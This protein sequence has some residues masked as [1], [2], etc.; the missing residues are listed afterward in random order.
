MKTVMEKHLEILKLHNELGE[1]IDLIISEVS[2]LIIEN[3]D[4]KNF[5]TQEMTSKNDL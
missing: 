4:L 5:I 2:N 1:A 3:N